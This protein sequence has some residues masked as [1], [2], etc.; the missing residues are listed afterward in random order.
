MSD[1]LRH[2]HR[3]TV[4]SWSE[5]GRSADRH[6]QALQAWASG[7]LDASPGILLRFYTQKSNPMTAVK[8]ASDGHTRER[9]ANRIQLRGSRHRIQSLIPQS[10]R[11]IM[12]ALLWE[13]KRCDDYPQAEAGPTTLYLYLA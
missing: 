2:F 11:K 9:P 13:R 6:Q 8:Q 12:K 5:R 1:I 3:S 10:L 7:E 4:L